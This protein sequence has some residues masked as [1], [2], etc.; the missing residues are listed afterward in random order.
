MNLWLQLG[1]V[2]VETRTSLR[3]KGTAD[4]YPGEPIFVPRPGAS[5]EDDGL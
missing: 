2:D 5:D 1:K 3:W 4:Q